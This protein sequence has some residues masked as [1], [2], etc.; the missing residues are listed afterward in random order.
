M[1]LINRDHGVL[2]ALHNKSTYVPIQ[3]SLAIANALY[4]NMVTVPKKKNTMDD[5]ITD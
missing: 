1:C 5:L 3:K 4:S 2:T